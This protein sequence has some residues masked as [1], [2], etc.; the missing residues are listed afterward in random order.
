MR[1]ANA[2]SS[3]LCNTRTYSKLVSIAVNSGKKA[4]Y[5]TYYTVQ[6]MRSLNTL[7]HALF[8]IRHNNNNKLLK[9]A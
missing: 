5:G 6:Q 3:T 2:R 7:N 4:I 8:E 9:N 1:E